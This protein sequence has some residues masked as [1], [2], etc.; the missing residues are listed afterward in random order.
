[1]KKGHIHPLRKDWLEI[2]EKWDHST[3]NRDESLMSMV[4]LEIVPRLLDLCSLLIELRIREESPRKARK[5]K[6]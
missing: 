6:K 1:M 5:V 2:K 3:K 4:A